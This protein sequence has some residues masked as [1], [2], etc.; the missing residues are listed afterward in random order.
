MKGI[1]FKPWKI[2]KIA[3]S[4]VGYRSVLVHEEVSRYEGSYYFS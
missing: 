2:K 1:L 4:P 3:D